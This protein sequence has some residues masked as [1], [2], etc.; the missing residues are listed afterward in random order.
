VYGRDYQCKIENAYFGAFDQKSGAAGSL[1]NLSNDQRLNHQVE[2]IS[3]IMEKECKE[4]LQ[5]FFKG[6]R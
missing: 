6:R 4:L 2:V 3:G 5:E 1:Y